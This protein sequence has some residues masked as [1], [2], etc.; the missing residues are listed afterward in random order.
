MDGALLAKNNSRVGVTGEL[1]AG[2]HL[3]QGALR[4]AGCDMRHRSGGRTEGRQL[5]HDANR[6]LVQLTNSLKRQ[7]TWLYSSQSGSDRSSGRVWRSDRKKRNKVRSHQIFRAHRLSTLSNPNTFDP[8]GLDQD[9]MKKQPPQYIFKYRNEEGFNVRDPNTLQ[10]YNPNRNSYKSLK[11][12]TPDNGKDA[13]ENLEFVHSK[14]E[15]W[16]V[17]QGVG[18]KTQRNRA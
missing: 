2:Y 14:L 12:Q 16:R 6:N 8:R 5:E 3:T 4:L 7:T 10:Q 11:L 9:A 13:N 1:R 18:K 17:L 15:E